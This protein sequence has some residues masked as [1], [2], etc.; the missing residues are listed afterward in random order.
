M[1]NTINIAEYAKT[2]YLEYAMSVVKGRAIAFIQDGCKPVHRRII[3]SMYKMGI[4][5]TSSPIKCA[6]VTGDVIGK[7]HP[8]GDMAV[9]EAM[10]LQTQPFRMRYP[11]IEGIGNFGSRDG[12]GSAAARY[13]ECKFYPIAR[14]L[15]DELNEEAV[16]M[17]PNYD[18]KENEPEF[19]PARVPLILLNPIEGIGVGMATNMPSHNITE[20]IKG[21]IA[22]L[23]N[24]EITIKEMLNY[25]KGPDFAT[26]AQLISSQN[27]IEKIYT[28]G[29]GSFKLRAKYFIENEGSKNWKLVFNEIPFGVSTKKVLEQ[30]FDLMN[31]EAK[32]KKDAKGKIKLSQEQERLKQLYIGLVSDYS[33]ESDKQNPLRL[34][35]TPKSHKQPV[36]ELVTL[37]LGTTS[38]EDNFSANFVIVGLDGNPTQKGLIT[39]IKEWS[40]FRLETIAKRCKYHIEK[41]KSRMHILEGRKMILDHL[42][43]V[44]QIVKES[45]DPKSDLIN[46]YGLTE[47][48]AQDVLELRLRQLGKLE[49]AGIQKEYKEIESKK[50]ELEKIIFSEKTLKKQMIKELNQDLVKFSDERKTEILEAE[51]IDLSKL[52]EK[53]IKIVEED[54]TI[55]LSDKG[56]VKVFK[57]KKTIDEMNFKEGD[58]LNYYFHCKNS[59]TL[60]IF[61]MDGKVY[62]YTI[63]DIAKDGVPV[64]TL[65]PLGTKINIIFPIN[66]EYKYVITQDSGVGFIVTGENLMTRQKAG[67][68]MVTMVE[69]SKLFQPL[70]FQNKEDKTAI[71]MAVITT[72]NK[73][74]MYKLNNISEIGKGKGVVI[75]GLPDNQKIKEVKI[76]RPNEEI[77]FITQGKNKKDLEFTLK[78]EDAILFE[79]GR[80]TKGGFLP[81][82]DKL[83]EI[84]FA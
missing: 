9:Y 66:K 58:K 76:I 44:I 47:I 21:V 83:S 34:V 39:I 24:T 82:K 38:L 67:K 73:F 4:S 8:H 60:A 74:L 79:K 59:D 50:I 41:I 77:K 46:A 54:V 13:T 42:D 63:T 43:A 2:S 52:Q 7:Y 72:E 32:A 78:P 11:I 22:Y 49:L 57:G 3:Y 68:E 61:D 51:K 81:I 84:K 27:E 29:K 12:D 75:C 1:K 53:S 16:N 70:F 55:A 56:W 64:N 80:S 18:G 14:T 71:R 26:G 23:E 65:V 19:M 28:E 31:P 69:D 62:N 45:E 35:I 17:V 25:I 6:R 10:V 37:L 40:T 15:F 20:V 48:Q 36:D 5:D 30:I 33:D